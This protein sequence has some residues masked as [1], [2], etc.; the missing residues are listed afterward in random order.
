[1]TN[2]NSTIVSNTLAKPQVFNTKG[3][4]GGR[5]RIAH[6][7]FEL[8]TADID[9]ADTIV[10]CY[11]PSS[12]I[13]VNLFLTNDDLDSN[14]SP[15]LAT[16]VGIYD[17]DPT[18]GTLGS[19]ADVDAFASAITQL[20]A[21]ANLTNILQEAATAAQKALIGKRLWEWAG[22]SSDPGGMLAIVLTISTVAATAVAGT[23]AFQ[24]GYV[25][26]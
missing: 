4:I 1:M 15:T 9:S 23:L 19:V 7:N 21:A 25:L 26:D 2:L 16:N 6:D 10:L 24:F 18:D 5:V 13:P 11:L 12:C 20:Q 8:S 22:K 17:V 14:G 3:K